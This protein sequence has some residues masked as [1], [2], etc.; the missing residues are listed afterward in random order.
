MTAPLLAPSGSVDV[1]LERACM[2]H[3]VCRFAIF[4]IVKAFHSVCEF[5]LAVLFPVRVG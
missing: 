3:L 4:G 5:L 2:T 1:E